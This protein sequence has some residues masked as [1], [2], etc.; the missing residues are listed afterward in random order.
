ME[1]VQGV[2]LRRQ[3]EEREGREGVDTGGDRAITLS[4]M[5][6]PLCILGLGLALAGLTF[7]AELALRSWGAVRPRRGVVRLRDLI[8][9]DNQRSDN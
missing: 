8:M 6:G 5:Q 2:N 4:H 7:M 3:R 9:K 1:E